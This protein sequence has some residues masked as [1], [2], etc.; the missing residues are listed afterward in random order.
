MVLQVGPRGAVGVP[1]VEA[2]DGDL[3]AHLRADPLEHGELEAAGRA[4]RGPLVHHDRVA[5]QRAHP[6][7][8][9][10]LAAA[11]QLVG[12]RVERGQRGRGGP[13]LPELLPCAGHL[14]PAAA[15][16]RERQRRHSKGNAGD[17]HATTIFAAAGKS[18]S[19]KL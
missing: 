2:E 9:G 5:A 15:A 10:G 1:G 19:F 3:G 17:A 4:P 12:L 6:R 13:Q 11:E 14:A 16:A 8:E 7:A 18:G